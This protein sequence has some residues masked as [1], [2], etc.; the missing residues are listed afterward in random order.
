MVAPG[1]GW[2]R[3]RLV[4]RSFGTLLRASDGRSL[5]HRLVPPRPGLTATL[6]DV[7]ALREVLIYVRA[8]WG[9][10][11]RQPTAGAVSPSCCLARRGGAIARP[12]PTPRA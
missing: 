1:C 11:P 5:N 2:V 9:R 6:G 8:A 10:E 3:I 4:G 12:S 7:Q